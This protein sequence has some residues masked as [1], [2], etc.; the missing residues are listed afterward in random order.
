MTKGIWSG[1]REVNVPKLKIMYKKATKVK[2][3][4]RDTPAMIKQPGLQLMNSNIR[5]H[6]YTRSL[7]DNVITQPAGSGVGTTSGVFNIRLQDIPSYTDFTNLYGSYKIRKL[8]FTFR[9][10]DAPFS[11]G[12]FPCIYAWKNTDPVATTFTGPLL[13]QRSNVRKY[14]TSLDNRMFEFSMYPYIQDTANST[15]VTNR[16]LTGVY[17][18]TNALAVPHYGLG[19]FIDNFAQAGNTNSGSIVIQYDVQV[20]LS[21]KS[22]E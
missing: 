6:R 5:I 16:P 15:S 14:Q 4:K 20:F 22:V 13:N 10:I 9:L 2:T 1:R 8:K 17:L 3:K 7:L 12:T 11:D 21:F 19:Y 18:D